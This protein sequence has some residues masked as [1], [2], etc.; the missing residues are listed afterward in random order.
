MSNV[1]HVMNGKNKPRMCS[2]GC[3]VTVSR[4]ELPLV[5]NQ[6][7]ESLAEA[8]KFLNAQACSSGWEDCS[9]IHHLALTPTRAHRFT[10]V[11]CQKVMGFLFL[12]PML[13]AH[14]DKV[15]HPFTCS[16]AFPPIPLLDHRPPETRKGPV[17]TLVGKRTGIYQ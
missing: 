12:T 5:R 4:R 16:S 11:H 14:F 3:Q 2:K 7:P 6:P 17:F 15:C 8:E 1:L 9:R 13:L 10:S